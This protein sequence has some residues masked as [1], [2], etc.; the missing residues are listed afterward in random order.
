MDEANDRLIERG[1]HPYATALVDDVT[2]E[3][4]DLSA[5]AAHHILEHGRASSGEPLSAG[6][7]VGQQLVRPAAGSRV[8]KA[9]GVDAVDWLDL[10]AAPSPDADRLRGDLHCDSRRT[11][12]A[13]DLRGAE[14]AETGDWIGHAVHRELRPTLAEKV[15]RHLGA[16]HV[17]HHHGQPPSAFG[18][19]AVELADL[20]ADRL[21][22][23]AQGMTGLVETGAERD[24]TAKRPPAPS[25]RRHSLII[26]AVLKVHDDPIGLSQ[27][28][29]HQRR[30]PF[31][32]VRVHCYECGVE[33]LGHRLQL[34]NVNDLHTDD[35]V[36]TG[37][38]QLQTVP[39]HRLHVL[40][41]LVN[42]RDVAAGLREHAA[43]HAADCPCAYDSNSHD[44]PP[45]LVD[46]SVALSPMLQC[47][48]RLANVA[49]LTYR[50]S[51]ARSRTTALASTVGL[52]VASGRRGAM[53][54]S[55]P[56]T[57]PGARGL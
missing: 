25:H 47:L 45:R 20:E 55:H 15:V 30:S 33:W 51:R 54:L 13:A 43:D 37:S 4:V 21:R 29:Q 49:A 5:P 18:V 52:R 50:F 44:V 16:G 24:V 31:G 34:V 28:R 3:E 48:I 42:Q 17:I 2:I 46:G 32:V 7:H 6:G 41:P 36:A 22:V 12:Y 38:R 40:R 19:L 53:L 23:G 26:D 1:L 10:E 8:H 11:R 39:S 56:R 14:T 9:L 27:V 35:V 57:H